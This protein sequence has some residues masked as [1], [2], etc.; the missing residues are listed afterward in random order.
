MSNSNAVKGVE[1]VK[2]SVQVADGKQSKGSDL[3]KDVTAPSRP[4]VK[5]KLPKSGKSPSSMH[6]QLVDQVIQLIYVWGLLVIDLHKKGVLVIDKAG[7]SLAWD[8]CEVDK[9][10]EVFN[11]VVTSLPVEQGLWVKDRCFIRFELISRL[12]LATFNEGRVLIV[13]GVDNRGMISF[14]EADCT[15]FDALHEH[16]QSVLLRE[17][18]NHEIDLSS[19]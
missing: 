10:V 12:Q 13:R 14:S 3:L 7:N 8:P 6:G 19:F 2:G 1:A 9:A 5:R 17:V 18:E 11:R 4:S 15:D 16:L